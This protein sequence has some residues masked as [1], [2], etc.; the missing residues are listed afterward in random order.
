MS[1]AAEDIRGI[2]N[3][4]TESQQLLHEDQIIHILKNR[5][6]SKQLLQWLRG[7]NGAIRLLN[8][9]KFD[10]ISTEELDRKFRNRELTSDELGILIGQDFCGVVV[11]WG[12]Y[13]IFSDSYNH[14]GIGNTSSLS[15]VEQKYGPV[16]K[17]YITS[18]VK[19]TGDLEKLKRRSQEKNRALGV[20]T[21]A[22]GNNNPIEPLI[23]KILPFMKS[24][25][26]ESL[27]NLKFRFKDAIDN[28]DYQTAEGISEHSKALTQMLVLADA[29]NIA[30]KDVPAGIRNIFLVILPNAYDKV[31]ETRPSAYF[32]NDLDDFMGNALS[33]SKKELAA[34]IR[35]FKEYMGYS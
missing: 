31:H 16:E 5:S 14:I 23:L 7:I 19:G 1:Q 28:N 2:L 34:I 10:E 12:R 26:T 11:N 17:A 6:G 24:A 20:I 8:G 30:R 29:T 4:L 35:S 3:I 33:G 22:R 9:A 18:N 25:I 21:R 13:Y 15:A 32:Q 27:Y